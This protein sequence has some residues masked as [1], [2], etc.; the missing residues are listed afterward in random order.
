MFET[1]ATALCGTTGILSY[2]HFQTAFDFVQQKKG[3]SKSSG[4]LPLSC[5]IL[6]FLEGMA[7]FGQNYIQHPFFIGQNTIFADKTTNVSPYL[8]VLNC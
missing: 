6:M 5:S 4:Q 2:V 8:M 1:S 7:I 3:N